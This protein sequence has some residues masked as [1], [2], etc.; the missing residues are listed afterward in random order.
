MN[1]YFFNFQSFTKLLD[2]TLNL[3]NETRVQNNISNASPDKSPLATFQFQ[4]KLKKV[5]KR[6]NFTKIDRFDNTFAQ[7]ILIPFILLKIILIN[8]SF[9]KTRTIK[10]KLTK[11]MTC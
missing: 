10:F 4:F 9:V 7:L 11:Y 5:T 8:V 2:N 3:L 6:A 1:Y